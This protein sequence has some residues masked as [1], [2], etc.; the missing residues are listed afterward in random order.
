MPSIVSMRSLRVLTSSRRLFDIVTWTS[1]IAPHRGAP[2]YSMRA[3]G[4]R[5]WVDR[6]GCVVI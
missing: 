6:I 2:R 5:A 4:N 3:D 1:S